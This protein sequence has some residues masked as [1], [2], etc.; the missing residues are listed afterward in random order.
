MCFQVPLSLSRA[1]AAVLESEHLSSYVVTRIRNTKLKRERQ[2]RLTKKLF[3]LSMLIRNLF[4]IMIR[5][6]IYF[7]IRYIS[8]FLSISSLLLP[9][10]DFMVNIFSDD[11]M[12]L[13]ACERVELLIYV[14]EI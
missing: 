2:K 5:L 9:F 6:V 3:N 13:Q 4:I 7:I 10:S 1:V 8:L 14:K 11:F 12:S